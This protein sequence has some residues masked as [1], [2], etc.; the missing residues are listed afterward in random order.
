MIRELH[1]PEQSVTVRRKVALLLT[2]LLEHPGQLL[3]K[4]EL[5]QAIWPDTAVTDNTLM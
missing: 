4:E 3:S 5:F 1:G 2:H